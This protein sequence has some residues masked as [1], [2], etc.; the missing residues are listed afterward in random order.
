MDS[1]PIYLGQ[2]SVEKRR[3]GF[4]THNLIP[5]SMSAILTLPE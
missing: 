3:I 5:M 2:N 1:Y 4:R